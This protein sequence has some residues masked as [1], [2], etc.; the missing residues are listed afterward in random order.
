VGTVSKKAPAL[1]VAIAKGL[2]LPK[3]KKR[4]KNH[5]G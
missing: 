4:K 1:W 5:A 3:R 2:K